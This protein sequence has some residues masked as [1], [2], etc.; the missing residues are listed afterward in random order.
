MS[1]AEVVVLHVMK[2][3]TVT[4]DD[5]LELMWMEEMNQHC[6]ARQKEVK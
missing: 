1:T 3:R 5:G 4:V 2:Y 6:M